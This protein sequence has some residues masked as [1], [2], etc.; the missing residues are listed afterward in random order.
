MIFLVETRYPSRVAEQMVAGMLPGGGVCATHWECSCGEVMGHERAFP[1]HAHN[2]GKPYKFCPLCGASSEC[3]GLSA[4]DIAG[5]QVVVR[6][7]DEVSPAWKRAAQ[8]TT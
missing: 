7:L 3:E 6:Y 8:E 5:Y 4:L 1:R 2:P